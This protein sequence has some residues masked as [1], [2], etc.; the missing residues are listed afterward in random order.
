MT[1]RLV[2]EVPDRTHAETK[3]AAALQGWKLSD[4]IRALLAAWL[5]GKVKLGEPPGGKPGK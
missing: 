4:L 2:V 3:A 1:K 5:S